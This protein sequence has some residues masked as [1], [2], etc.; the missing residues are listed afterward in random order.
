MVVGATAPRKMQNIRAI[1]GEDVPLL[2]PGIG[3]QGGDLASCMKA[4][5]NTSGTGI[6]IS[7]SRS[8]IYAEGG[9][10]FAYAA[11]QATLELR[12]NINKYR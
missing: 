5:K 8:I 10:N 6:I 3:T 12:D 1:V 11:C 2:V 4:G 7:S 9:E